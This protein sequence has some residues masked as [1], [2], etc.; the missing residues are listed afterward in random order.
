MVR[1]TDHLYM[2]ITV[3][4]DVKHIPK[5]KFLLAHLSITFSREVIVGCPSLYVHKRFI[6]TTSYFKGAQW[7]SGRVLDLRPRG[8]GFQPLWCHYVVSLSKA[9]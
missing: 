2:T 8:C 7:L 5:K 6:H 1:L 4:W 3:H 9:H